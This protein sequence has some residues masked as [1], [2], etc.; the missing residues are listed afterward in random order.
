M[1]AAAELAAPFVPEIEPA[2]ADALD[3]Y[4]RHLE[5]VRGL[6]P[7]TIRNYRTDLAQFLRWLAAAEVPLAGLA[8]AHYRRWLAELQRS[9]VADASIRRRAST[10]KSFIRRLR[11][12]GELPADPLRL[13]SV[14]RGARRLPKPLS[15]EQIEAL[16]Q[17]PDPETPAGI[18]DRAV[19]ETLYSCGIRISELAGMRLADYQ[20]DSRGFIVRGKGGRERAVLLGAPA[21]RALRAWLRDGRPAMATDR[22]ADALWLNQRGGRLGVRAVQLALK[23]HAAAAGL[24]PDIHPHLLRH[25]FATH[26][27]DGGANLR[28]V[29]ELLGHASVSTTQLYTHVTESGKRAA[30]DQAL[31]GIAEH[32]RDRRRRD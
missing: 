24:P 5:S 27:L 3:R 10:V 9:G 21:E 4:L 8:R 11:I 7:H 1:P 25:S 18:R 31:D 16:L 29:Q 20:P 15:R 30:I 22:S 6:S 14:P 23:R 19:I 26:M 13:A 12:T 28:V 17:A 2:A 32:L